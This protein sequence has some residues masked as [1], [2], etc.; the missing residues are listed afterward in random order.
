MDHQRVGTYRT[1][2]FNYGATVTC[3]IRG[4]VQIVGPSNGR[5]AW[6]K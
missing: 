6:P 5:I 4:Q 1:P 3:A 2:R